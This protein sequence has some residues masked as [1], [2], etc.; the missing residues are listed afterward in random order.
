MSRLRLPLLVDHSEPQL[1]GEASVPLLRLASFGLGLVRHAPVAFSPLPPHCL[2][3]THS[4]SS[5]DLL[6]CSLPP[7]QRSS[8]GRSVLISGVLSQVLL[9]ESIVSEEVSIQTVLELPVRTMTCTGVL[10]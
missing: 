1:V 6:R 4:G 5:R 3:E 8:I 10:G 9:L 7:L 2:I